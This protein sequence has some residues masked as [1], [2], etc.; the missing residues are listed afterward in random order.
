MIRDFIVQNWYYLI[1]CLIGLVN[2]IIILCKKNKIIQEDTIFTKLLEVLPIMIRKAEETGCP[3]DEK[4]GLVVTLAINWLC[5]HTGKKR[6]DIIDEYATRIGSAI[7][8]ILST[9]EKKGDM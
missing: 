7:E 1:L 3:G 5:E 2:M 6:A 8:N 9:P 4:F